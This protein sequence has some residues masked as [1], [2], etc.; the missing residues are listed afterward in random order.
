MKDKQ[1]LELILKFGVAEQAKLK[2]ATRNLTTLTAEWKKMQAEADR[3]RK[4]VADALAEG[5]DATK[6]KANLDNIEKKLSLIS[7]QAVTTRHNL[8][9]T[10][11]QNL[12]KFGSDLQRIGQQ[13]AVFGGVGL[14]AL[15]G[16]AQKYVSERPLDEA[17]IRWLQ[18]QKDIEQSFIRIGGVAAD[19]LLPV[20]E[21]AAEL[22]EDVAEFFEKNPDAM[23]AI[24]G[25]LGTAAVV[26]SLV[27][28]AGQASSV[29]GTVTKYAPGAA[30]ALSGVP[31]AAT[32]G[33]GAAAG[34]GALGVYGLSISG[35]AAIGKEIANAIQ[36]ATGQKES[37]WS[38]ILTTG[39]QTLAMLGPTAGAAYAAKALGFD[40]QASQ[41]WD[42][43]QTIYGLGD[44]AE[45]AGN[46][47]A[48]AG[49]N[50]FD[51]GFAQQNV[52]AW[53]DHNKQLAQALENYE[54]R[55]AEIEENGAARRLDIIQRFGEQAAQA[56]SRYSQARADAI[57]KFT[58]REN[59][60]ERDY[61]RSRTQAAAQH[62]VAVRRAEQDHQR[63]LEK[64]R[65]DHNRRMT[66]LIDDR[67]AFG[68]VREQQRY[69]E[70]RA[71]A[72]D[73][74]RIQAARRSEDFARQLSEMEEN[75]RYQ[76][77]IRLRDF[78]Q[79]QE[80]AAKRHAEEMAMMEQNKA[81]Q[82]ALLDKSQAEQLKKLKDGYDRQVRM[83]ET[84][85][86]DRLNAMSQSIRGNTDAWVKYMR[87]S[88]ADFEAWLRALRG[89][90]NFG[91]RPLE[92]RALGGWVNESR[93]YMV[94]ERGP[95]MFVPHNSGT[96]VPNHQIMSGRRAGGGGNADGINMRIE[97]QSLTLQQVMREVDK[98]LTKHTDMLARALE[99][100]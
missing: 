55:K 66:E 45:G 1:V 21:K 40:E 50:A 69:E 75:F 88:A 18:A 49:R 51:E 80:E 95:E 3:A 16:M 56:E 42:L 82:L 76:R 4:A 13:M 54:E 2:D 28:A 10:F 8:N 26:G 41:L 5:R 83:M 89:Q 79:Q 90:Y 39:K 20:L 38:D 24:V 7:M 37:S 32:L 61:Y 72:E 71:D 59:D 85:F 91:S 25:V 34:L 30:G 100:R 44:A 33:G 35:G 14:A 70:A 97:T 47:V 15:G 63:A 46:K 31:G 86:I 29:L 74:Y 65:R 62:G 6:L 96:I 87:Q 92:Y 73:S 93:P 94:G 48:Q 77:S 52:Q 36:S 84:A 23:K 9:L 81:E 64:L 98:R 22:S 43:T 99:G 67:D 53:I 58:Q 78:R 68:I 12:Q 11:S 17:S 19:A 57:A 27:K 60:I